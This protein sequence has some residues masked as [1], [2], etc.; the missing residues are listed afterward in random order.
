MHKQCFECD[1]KQVNKIKKIL[2][3][4]K[5]EETELGDIV[6]RYLEAIDINKTNPEVMGE[7]WNLI[8]DY[9]GNNNP[10][11]EIKS[12]YN[13]AVLM[14][15]DE[16]EEIICSSD[17]P[18]YTAI[19]IAIIGNLIDFSA[20]HQFDLEILKSMINDILNKEL[21]IN[22]INQLKVDLSIAKTVLYIG[23]NCGEIVLDKIFIKLLK[24]LYP[25]IH[26]YF[27]VRGQ[28]IINDVTIDDAL[29]V[30]MEEVADII[31]NGDGSL[32]TVLNKTSKEFKD[33]FKEV[34]VVICKGQGNYEGLISETRKNL[35]FMFMAK[36]DIIAKPLGLEMLSI[37]CMK[38]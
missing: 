2:S 5:V 20:N 32:G 35:Y 11:K 21:S 6:E 37:V 26:F 13:Q 10:Y 27:G 31:S 28:P 9:T 15:K 12:Y 14:V 18:Y 36:C 22:D 25:E 38:K 7:I 17:D 1:K 29:E 3:L 30:N 33:R 19:K 8:S 34:D 24:K 4:N 23:D 16:V